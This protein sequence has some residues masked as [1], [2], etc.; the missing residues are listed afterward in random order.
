MWGSNATYK[1]Q[2]T[3]PLSAARIETASRWG[4]SDCCIE[5]RGSCC[6]CPEGLRSP[7]VDRYRVARGNARGRR[8]TEEWYLHIGFPVAADNRNQ[9]IHSLRDLARSCTSFCLFAEET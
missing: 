1:A 6:L 3:C 7:I 9:R 2:A 4:D 8:R 5:P